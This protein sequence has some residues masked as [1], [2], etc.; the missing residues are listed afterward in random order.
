MFVID[1]YCFKKSFSPKQ[2]ISAELHIKAIYQA[3]QH[4][5]YG[6]EPISVG[7]VAASMTAIHRTS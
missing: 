6:P 4:N 3:L 1:H 7:L 5:I 2:H